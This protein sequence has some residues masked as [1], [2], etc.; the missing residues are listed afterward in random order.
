MSHLSHPALSSQSLAK[1]FGVSAAIVDASSI[2]VDVDRE[3]LAVGSNGLTSG[4]DRAAQEVVL[5]RDSARW[6]TVSV[7]RSATASPSSKLIDVWLPKDRKMVQRIVDIYFSRLNHHRPV[8][9]KADFNRELDALYNEQI[10][11]HDPGFICSFYLILALGTLSELNQLAGKNGIDGSIKQEHPGLNHSVAKKLMPDWPEYDEFFERALTIKPD[12]R[13]TISSLQA[14]ILL[15]WFLYIE[16]RP[17]LFPS[18]SLT[19][20]FSVKVVP[21]GA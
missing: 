19:V 14:L 13:V 11:V 15:H 12:L 2:E 17:R 18:H 9:R 5:P 16:V 3:D 8:F 20:S 7:R 6:T 4:R 21:S 10:T 1:T